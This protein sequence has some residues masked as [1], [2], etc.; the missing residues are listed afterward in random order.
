VLALSRSFYRGG[1]LNRRAVVRSA[2]SQVLFVVRGADHERMER[3][4]RQVTAL[5]AGWEV[6]L[7]RDIIAGAIQE[8]IG[9]MVYA[10]AVAL[11]D[12]HHA[13]GREVVI[14]ST[15]SEEIVGPIG[16]LL[17]VDRVI[18]SRMVEHEG[19]WTGAV[20]FYAYGEA[21][22][23]A[24]QDLAARE[25]YDL[26]ASY[27]YSDSATDLPMLRAVGHPVAVNPDRLLRREAVARGWPVRR[28]ERP[29]DLR[30]RVRLPSPRVAVTA[31]LLVLAGPL[32][33]ALLRRG[34]T[35][36]LA[37]LLAEDLLSRLPSG[38]EEE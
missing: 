26:S 19:R 4:R 21:K 24:M 8:L 23:T 3:A 11:I 32:T 16:E 25:G 33:L 36:D 29:V 7:V 1:L 14:V 30:R 22:A 38:P 12:Q 15:S 2:V 6:Q 10:E 13:A 34:R 17:G 28:F 35:P 9:P 37:T 31:S 5:T 20:G 18:A 27:A